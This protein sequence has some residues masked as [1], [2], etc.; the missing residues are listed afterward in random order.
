MTFHEI[1]IKFR[2]VS[3]NFINIWWIFDEMFFLKKYSWNYMKKFITSWND[4]RQRSLR[5]RDRFHFL[6]VMNS[7]GKDIHFKNSQSVIFQPKFKFIRHFVSSAF[8]STE[9]GFWNVLGNCQS[10]RQTF[11]NSNRDVMS[12]NPFTASWKNAMSISVQGVPVPCEK[13]PHSIVNWI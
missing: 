9:K 2:E 5:E 12:F 8:A 11:F 10:L 1:F 6:L 3:W 13:F 4:F 7:C